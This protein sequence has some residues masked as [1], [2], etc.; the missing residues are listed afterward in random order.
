MLIREN[1]WLMKQYAERIDGREEINPEAQAHGKRTPT[2]DE[3]I[4][5]AYEA[6]GEDCVKHLHRRLRIC[7]LGRAVYSVSSARAIT[8]A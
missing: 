6:W 1:L 4:L 7:D 3:L 2:D 8:S 5:L